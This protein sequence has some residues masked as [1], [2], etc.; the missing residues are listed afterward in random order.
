VALDL[1]R[2]LVF[3]TVVDRNGYS[4][5]A[6]HLHLAQATVSHHVAGLEKSLGTQ[7]LRY[8][9]GAVSLTV[10]GHEVYRVARVMLREQD[11][12]GLFLDDLKFGRSG[13]VRLGASMAF[14][15]EYFF[16]KVIM[17]FRVANPGVF[18]SLRFGH[19]SS[20]AQA[21]LDNELDLAYVIRWHL[22]PDVDF[23]PLH[24]ARFTFVAPRN[25]PLA[26]E[27]SVSIDDIAEAGLITAP[28]TSLESTYYN[29]VLLDCGLT[30]GRSVLE[31]DGLQAR[32]LA[33]DAGLGILGTFIPAYAGDDGRGRL[34]PLPVEGLLPEVQIGLISRQDESPPAGADALADWLRNVPS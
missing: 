23:E 32:L 14:E 7:L 34:V 33:A 20:H 16:Q 26:G 4:A 30:P 8:R 6:R 5:A 28:G 2:L 25:H 11:R 10:A 29:Q 24:K 3:V 13:R 21:V 1:F 31:V 9:Q 19:S 27:A 15:Q 17:P 18:L 22:P 12:L